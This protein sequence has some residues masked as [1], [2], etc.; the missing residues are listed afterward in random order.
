MARALIVAQLRVVANERAACDANELVLDVRLVNGKAPEAILVV[1][2][3]R[4]LVLVSAALNQD[5][6]IRK[7]IHAA[8]IAAVYNHVQVVII[9]IRI[10]RKGEL[11]T[12]A[13]RN[14]ANTILYRHVTRIVL[15][16]LASIDSTMRNQH[17]ARLDVERTAVG[18]RR[19]WLDGFTAQINN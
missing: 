3:F 18:T 4:S 13:N 8:S 19:L 6:T 10:V 17:V 15:M 5:N 14:E 11:R 7:R 2:R 1:I 12:S 9:F 16:N